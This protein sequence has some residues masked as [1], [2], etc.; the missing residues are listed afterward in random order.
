MQFFFSACFFPFFCRDC[1]SFSL[2]KQG[3]T[4]AH[5][6]YYHFVFLLASLFSS[7][8][9]R[10]FH[11]HLLKQSFSASETQVMVRGCFVGRLTSIRLIK[12]DQIKSCFV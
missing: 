12:R 1:S 11:A 5:R 9:E 7:S 4:T 3:M 10:A 8:L 2:L 6:F